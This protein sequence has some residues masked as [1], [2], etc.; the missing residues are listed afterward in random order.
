MLEM[1]SVVG[2][3]LAETSGVVNLGNQKANVQ[4]GFEIARNN[5]GCIGT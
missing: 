4:S 5:L 1:Y 2:P 3:A